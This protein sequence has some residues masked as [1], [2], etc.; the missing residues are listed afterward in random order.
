MLDLPTD[1]YNTAIGMTVIHKED[2]NVACSVCNFEPLVFILTVTHPIQYTGLI[3]G[4][5]IT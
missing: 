3:L 2:R 4:Q 5:P 1:C